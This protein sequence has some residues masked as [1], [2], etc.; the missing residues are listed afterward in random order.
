MNWLRGLTRNPS[1]QAKQDLLNLP[2]VNI[3]AWQDEGQQ[4]ELAAI[5]R[6]PIIRM[7][8]RIVSESIPVPMPSHGSKESDIIF[9]AGVTAGYAHCLENLRKLAVF[10]A[11][12][13]PEATFDK[14]Y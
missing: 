12:R 13:E 1:K 4:A 6:N 3:S 5:M 14:Q 8:I 9:A 7:A 2:E 10:E 11:A